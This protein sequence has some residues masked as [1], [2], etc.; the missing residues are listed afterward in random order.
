VKLTVG[1]YSGFVATVTAMG[2]PAHVF[3]EGTGAVSRAAALYASGDVVYYAASSPNP[4]GAV[5][6]AA[7]P[8]A[9]L[10][11]GLSMVEV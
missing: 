5:F 8:A 9:V 4:T 3:Y 10:V 6:V 1:A 7:Y 2:A 11:T